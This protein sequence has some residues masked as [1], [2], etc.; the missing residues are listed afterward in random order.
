M[1]LKMRGK[2]REPIG[3]Q[4]PVNEDEAMEPEKPGEGTAE[5]EETL[6]KQISGLE[7]MVNKR[8]RE[9]EDAKVQLSQLSTVAEGTDGTKEEAQVDELFTQPNQPAGE[10]SVPAEEEK[11]DGEKE[12][13]ALLT[14]TEKKGEEKSGSEGESDMLS[15][16]FSQEDEEENPLAGLITTLPDV[17]AAELLDEAKEIEKM[18]QEWQPD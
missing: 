9:L 11:P 17:A 12:P 2:S 18:M 14:E 5:S 13:N 7:D 16:I 10:S 8:T 3:K 1:F 4:P 6:V 15:D